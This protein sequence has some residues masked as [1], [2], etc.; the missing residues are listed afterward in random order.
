[1]QQQLR[2]LEAQVTTLVDDPLCLKLEALAGEVAKVG[3]QGH[4]TGIKV[5]SDIPFPKWSKA[6]GVK[7]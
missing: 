5:R 6:D 2:D 1:M 4:N 3:S 7:P